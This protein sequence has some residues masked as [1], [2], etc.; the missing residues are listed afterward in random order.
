MSINYLFME[1][2]E[3]LREMGFIATKPV[4]NPQILILER[5][6]IDIIYS[7]ITARLLVPTVEENLKLQEKIEK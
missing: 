5:T 1:N 2:I 3:T 4:T 7:C 6:E